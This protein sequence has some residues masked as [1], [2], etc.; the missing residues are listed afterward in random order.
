MLKLKT[1]EWSILSINIRKEVKNII[2]RCDNTKVSTQRNGTKRRRWINQNTDHPNI[3]LK[4]STRQKHTSNDGD[5][6]RTT[7]EIEVQI[8]SRFCNFDIIKHIFMGIFN[9]S[10][11][12]SLEVCLTLPMFDENLVT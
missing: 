12:T 1:K 3:D 4:S 10:F 5:K 11:H 6:R 8:K 7:L 9:G 2:I